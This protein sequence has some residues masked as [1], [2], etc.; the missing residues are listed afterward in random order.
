MFSLQ[1]PLQTGLT[2][3]NIYFIV[4]DGI[5][6]DWSE[7]SECSVT[8]GGG[9]QKMERSCNNPAP[10]HGGKPCEGDK[11]QTQ[12]CNEQACPGN[13]PLN[14]FLLLILKYPLFPL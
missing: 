9:V 10:L 8:C 7:V 6:S 4:V 13:D 1:C 12:K 14:Y 5:W 11:T 2:L 3:Q